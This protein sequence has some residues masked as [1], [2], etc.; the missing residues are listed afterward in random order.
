MIDE[1]EYLISYANLKSGLFNLSNYSNRVA[2]FV[3]F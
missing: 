2:S 1:E 3:F